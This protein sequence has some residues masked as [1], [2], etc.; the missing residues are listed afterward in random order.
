MAQPWKLVHASDI[1]T[2]HLKTGEPCQ[3]ASFGCMVDDILIA[4]VADGAGTASHSAIGSHVACQQFAVVAADALRQGLSLSAIDRQHILA[5]CDRA[6][7]Q[8]ALEA[9]LRNVALRELSCTFLVA[10]A[11]TN[12]AVF[13]QIGDGAIVIASGSDYRT[14]FW[15]QSGEYANTTYFLSAD[16]WP[17]HIEIAIVDEP[18]NELGM[19]SDGLQ[20][21]ALTY[22]SQTVHAPFF[23]P[24]FTA[25]HRAP[26][27]DAMQSS[28]RQFLGSARINERTDDDKTLLLACR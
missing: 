2:S 7:R 9:C 24:L 18:V 3:D 17:E 8:L 11:G 22:A 10:L 28:L 21:L 20:M 16:D 26:T 15:P 25:L 6:R 27:A 5:W 12:R 1:G 13:A 19:F 4:C 23:R 14:V